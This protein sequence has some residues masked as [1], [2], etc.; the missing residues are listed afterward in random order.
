MHS[1]A[2][3]W[4]GLPVSEIYIISAVR[5]PIG[6]FLGSLSGIPAPDL[7][8]IAAKEAIKR[9]GIEPKD[10]DFYAFGNVI[11]AAVG[12]NPARRTALLA[13][14]PYEV[15]G[16]TVNLVCSSGMMAMID[17]IRA[18]KAGDAKIALVGGM[19]SMSRAPLCLPPEARSGIKHL[20]GR[21]AKLID[22]MVLDGLTDSWNW[23]LMGVEADMT[24]KKYG[25]KREELD[26]IAYQSH[27]RAAK[28]TDE[29]IFEKE[30]VPIE[31]KTK[32]G[33]VTIKSD[34]GIRRDTSPEKL[35]KLPPAF[36]PDGVHT[37]GNSSQL[38]DGAAAL[39]MAPEEVVNEYGLKPVARVLAYDIVGLKPEDFVEAPVPGIKRISEK[40]G[41]KPDDWDL[42][43]VN[44][45]FAISLWLPHHLLGIPYERMN[46]HGGA[47]A[48]G[49][50]LGASGAR[51]VVTL[52]NAL[53]THNKSRGVATLCHGTGGGS[54]L[55]IE[56]F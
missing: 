40:V 54:T 6:K 46:V 45:A 1:G 53:K 18:F 4:G 22:T 24:A 7:A 44:E 11:G 48:I 29:G 52:I 38:S 12:Q 23:Q 41:V 17:A 8:A 13:G 49:H 42:Y 3:A 50:P 51:I 30:I 35:A 25:A 26:W 15:D 27:M 37:A 55:A 32:K 39:I 21:E 28:A 10:V 47:I 19:E 56:V 9:A 14:I 33:V 5:T 36:T 20:V 43:E 2:P 34:E 16:H 31:V